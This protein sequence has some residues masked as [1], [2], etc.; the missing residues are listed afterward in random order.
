[1]SHLEAVVV[2][3]LR[4]A[5]GMLNSESNRESVSKIPK[6]FLHIEI[7][8]EAATIVMLLAIAYISAEEWI[9]RSVLFFWT[10][11]FRDLFYYLSLYILIKWPSKLT[12]T[13]L[14][15]LI[16]VPWLAPVWFPIVVS[17]LTIVTIL[18]LLFFGVIG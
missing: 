14:L 9:D 2:V 4:K 17:S 11:T 18:I 7:S 8:R 3:Y 6:K 12:E 16:P 10:F 1:M 13:D 15:F 5:L